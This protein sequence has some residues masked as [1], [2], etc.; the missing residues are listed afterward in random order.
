MGYNNYFQQKTLVNLIFP[1]IKFQWE[2]DY[3]AL[4]HQYLLKS[5]EITLIY[6]QSRRNVQIILSIKDQLLF[7]IQPVVVS[8][9]HFA[10]VALQ[11]SH[12][13]LFEH[14]IP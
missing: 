7:Q 11:L 13:H 9:E 2:H 8:F 1:Y 10:F 14:C 6:I 4:I 3:D 12:R 5:M